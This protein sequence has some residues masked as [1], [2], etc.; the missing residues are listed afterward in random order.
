MVLAIKKQPQYLATEKR[1]QQRTMAFLS[2]H[3]K[4]A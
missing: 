1:L 2:Q 3:P 4:R